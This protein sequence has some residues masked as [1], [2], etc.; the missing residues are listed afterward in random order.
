MGSELARIVSV[1]ENLDPISSYLRVDVNG[2]RY[3]S[4]PSLDDP[5]RSDLGS[6]ALAGPGG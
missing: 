1:A 4:Q 5:A 6:F 2:L 3:R